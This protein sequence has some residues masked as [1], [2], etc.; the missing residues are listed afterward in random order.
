VLFAPTP[1]V[2]DIAAGVANERGDELDSP[3]SRRL[4]RFAAIFSQRLANDL[5]ASEPAS[6]RNPIGG[7]RQR[8]GKTQRRRLHATQ[9]IT[10]YGVAQYVGAYT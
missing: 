4:T 1:E 6:F 9:C 8:I 10:Q 2:T 7:P 3:L 5:G